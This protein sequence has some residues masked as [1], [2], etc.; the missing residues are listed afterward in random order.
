MASD[1]GSLGHVDSS[2]SSASTAP[3]EG[4]SHHRHEPDALAW[5][6][7]AGDPRLHWASDARASSEARGFAAA[8][9]VGV[10][11]QDGSSEGPRRAWR[12]KGDDRTPWLELRFDATVRAQG[13]LVAETHAAGAV[14]SAEDDR[15]NVLWRAPREPLPS[16][17]P[18]L[19]HVDFGRIVTLDTLRL[20]LSHTHGERPQIDAVALVTTA[21]DALREPPP[22]PPIPGAPEEGFTFLEGTLRG[23]DDEH[24]LAH[25][26]VATRG[27][28]VVCAHGEGLSLELESGQ[29]VALDIADT[30]VFGTPFP[31]RRA[32]FAEIRG[33]HPWL[34]MALGE[35]A[36]ADDEDT[37]IRGQALT[38][39]GR[40]Y[41]AGVVT[42]RSEGGFRESAGAPTRMRAAAI[43]LVPLADTSFP[44]RGTGAFLRDDRPLD[45]SHGL[46]QRYDTAIRICGRIVA[47]GL[48]GGGGLAAS[49]WLRPTTSAALSVIGLI[50]FGV[51]FA[52]L[53]ILCEFVARSATPIVWER[54]RKRRPNARPRLPAPTS[55]AALLLVAG[56]LG[57]P[58]A[59]QLTVAID[60]PPS[61]WLVS[62]LVGGLASLWRLPSWLLACAPALGRAWLA[63]LRGAAARGLL[64]EE[65]SVREAH[66]DHVEIVGTEQ[67][68]DATGRM[69]TLE[70]RRSWTTRS[71]HVRGQP[72]LATRDGG[73]IR[74]QPSQIIVAG[75]TP[76]RSAD[77]NTFILEGRFSAGDLVWTTA[78]HTAKDG[79]LV[80]C[81]TRTLTSS[82]V[83]ATA[84]MLVAL[85]VV[86]LGALAAWR[87]FAGA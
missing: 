37:E 67:R 66:T 11:D 6:D 38:R 65:L 33:A 43:S 71:L 14:V 72:V 80:L 2:N 74:L 62:L 45:S 24:P 82:L 20:H 27:G 21:L 51:G 44:E 28:A 34:S 36:P 5:I 77:A 87:V 85:L 54:D 76:A 42:A 60:P 50:G 56:I 63:R 18:R 12:P 55:A 32:A 35:R 8:R 58:A 10:P 17:T 39:G 70:H 57:L 29:T 75:L 59:V 81:D 25:V 22:P 1:K 3:F 68:V 46:P 15:G 84:A 23:I 16:T 19:L 69:T 40:V 73:R 13:V 48:G 64:A 31:R 79:A 9:V 30:T 86:A 78:A 83:V 49:A 61:P 52:V 4:T 41:V 53:P 47:V 7:R 26:A